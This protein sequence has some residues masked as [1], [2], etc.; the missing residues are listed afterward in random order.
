M[1][2][3][4]PIGTGN[5]SGS[6]RP[7][8]CSGEGLRNPPRRKRLAF[9][10]SVRC[11]WPPRPPEEQPNERHHDQRQRAADSPHLGID[12]ARDR[13]GL[14]RAKLVPRVPGRFSCRRSRSPPAPAAGS[15][16]L[17]HIPP[18]PPWGA[19]ADGKRALLRFNRPSGSVIDLSS[20]CLYR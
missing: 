1:R 10:S 5:L 11:A 17:P 3:E 2:R 18:V 13:F 16:L 19:T 12:G 15:A 20:M 4:R 6:D 9:H 14:G 7:V 8:T